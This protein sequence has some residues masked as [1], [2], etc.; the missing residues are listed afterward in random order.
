MADEA[1]GETKPQPKQ[2]GAIINLVVKDQTGAEVHFKVKN[3]T[4]LEKVI[5]VG[6]GD[7]VNWSHRGAAGGAAGPGL[8]CGGL[9]AA[10]QRRAGACGANVS[11]PRRAAPAHPQAYCQKKAIEQTS[12]R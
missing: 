12:V 11:P 8:S 10:A 2:E 1:T 7:C 6:A 3:H 5:Q 4:K 9:P